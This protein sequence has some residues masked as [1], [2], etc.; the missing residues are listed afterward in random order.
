MTLKM[1]RHISIDPGTYYFAVGSNSHDALNNILASQGKTT[2]DGMTADGNAS[3][4]ILLE[5]GWR[6]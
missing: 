2:A 3:L 4:F 1:Q 6:C 5:L